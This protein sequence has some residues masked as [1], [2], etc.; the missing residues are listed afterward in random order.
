[1]ETSANSGSG[2]K[3]RKSFWKGV[4]VAALPFFFLGFFYGWLS[5]WIT[6]VNLERGHRARE[7]E[8]GQIK[9]ILFLKEDCLQQTW[10]IIE[11]NRRARVQGVI[12][13]D[14]TEEQ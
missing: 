13:V 6:Y 7:M 2:K 12:I 1:M 5:V 3:C 9:R 11:W 4:A 10:D 8:L 14:P